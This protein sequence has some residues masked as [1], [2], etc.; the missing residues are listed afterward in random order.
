LVVTSIAAQLSNTHSYPRHNSINP[1]SRGD[2]MAKGEKRLCKWKED[3]IKKKFDEF[4]S[5]VR[6]P[7]F[8]CIKCGRVAEKKK[9]LHKPLALN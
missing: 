8:V 9:R 2:I 5:L 1:V 6:E 7:K 3:D 4:V